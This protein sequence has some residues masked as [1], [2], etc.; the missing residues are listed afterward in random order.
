M[1]ENLEAAPRKPQTN[2][3][4]ESAG[5]AFVYSTSPKDLVNIGSIGHPHPLSSPKRFFPK[6]I[7]EH[8]NLPATLFP[9]SVL[10]RYTDHF[11]SIP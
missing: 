10:T 6:L 5:F 8:T 11:L 9:S 1:S 4:F 7:Q 2:V 3:A